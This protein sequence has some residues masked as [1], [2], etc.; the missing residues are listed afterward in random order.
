MKVYESKSIAEMFGLMTDG[1][2]WPGKAMSGLMP[3]LADLAS[4]C[5]TCCEFGIRTGHSTVALL[6]GSGGHVHSWDIERLDQFHRPIKA[7]A[8]DRW[9]LNYGRSEEADLPECDLLLHDSLHTYSQVKAE[10]DAHQSK[11]S[12]FIAF[13][14]TVACGQDGLGQDGRWLPGQGIVKAINEMVDSGLWRVASHI[15]HSNGMIVL[16]RS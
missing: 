11:V 2:T 4:K 1:K 3:F 14:D 15:T 16:Q 8:G 5:S 12:R 13:H 7:L 10:M 6:H 9:H